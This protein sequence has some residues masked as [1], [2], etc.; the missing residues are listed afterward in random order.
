MNA[1]VIGLIGV[2]VGGLLSAG[3]SFLTSRYT[4]KRKERREV[5]QA[6]RLVERE[7]WRALLAFNRVNKELKKKLASIDE[8]KTEDEAYVAV[9]EEI[10]VPSDVFI[11]G[12]DSGTIKPV[13]FDIWESNQKILA[14]AL[15]DA[16]WGNVEGAYDRIVELLPTYH[17]VQTRRKLPELAD[18]PR[19][20]RAVEVI[21]SALNSLHRFSRF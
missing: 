13:T 3:S 1:A 9:H 12:L 7:L 11:S 8:A 4:E 19:F 14:I 21:E 2:V 17:N 15:P 10:R 20:E 16:T 18:E 6:A 5:R